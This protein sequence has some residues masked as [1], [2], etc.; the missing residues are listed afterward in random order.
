MSR[1]PFSSTSV[2]RKA[3]E[4]W[5][6]PSI[7][8]LGVPSQAWET[9]NATSQKRFNTQLL[10][11]VGFFGFTVLVAYNTVESNGT[12]AFVNTTGF[13]TKL[14]GDIQLSLGL[15]KLTIDDIDE[16]EDNNTIEEF[17]D[18]VSEDV[19][20][21][22]T[23]SFDEN[24]EDV[25]MVEGNSGQFVTNGSFEAGK[26]ST[27]KI[28]FLLDSSEVS[29]DEDI[30]MEKK[31]R[32][33][34]LG[35]I[36]SEN[37]LLEVKA[38]NGTIEVVEEWKNTELNEL[39][40]ND[41][42]ITIVGEIPIDDQIESREVLDIIDGRSEVTDDAVLDKAKEI[43]VTETADNRKEL[44]KE[45][46]GIKV[47]LDTAKVM[48]DVRNE[49]TDQKSIV[50]DST[51]TDSEVKVS[52]DFNINMTEKE[53]ICN[54]NLNGT[55]EASI[56]NPFNERN[57]TGNANI[58]EKHVAV[59]KMGSDVV[60]DKL[61]NPIDGAMVEAVF[62]YMET[63][64]V[65]VGKKAELEYTE[66]E[67]DV[68]K[69]N[70]EDRNGKEEVSIVKERSPTEVED[71]VIAKDGANE[72]VDIIRERDS[73]DADQLSDFN[74]KVITK[75]A[76][77]EVS[78]APNE[79]V[80]EIIAVWKPAED[81]LKQVDGYIEVIHI[82]KNEMDNENQI[83]AWSDQLCQE[84]SVKHF[85]EEG[86]NATLEIVAK[87]SAP[88]EVNA[89]DGLGVK[90]VHG[91]VGSEKED[92]LKIIEDGKTFTSE[93]SAKKIS[94]VIE[95]DAKDVED[96][97]AVIAKEG[98]NEEVDTIRGRDSKDTDPLSDVSDKAITKEAF[99]DGVSNAQ[100]EGVDEIIA[101]WKPSEDKVKPIDGNIE[102]IYIDKNEEEN[103]RQEVKAW[104]D[105][106][107][108]KD[109]VK[110][111]AEEI[112]DA[113][114]EIVAKSAMPDEVNANDGLGVKLVNGV[115]GSENEEKLEIVEDGQIFTSE[116]S[117][118]KIS[119]IIE[120]DAKDEVKDKEKQND[121]SGVISTKSAAEVVIE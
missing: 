42:K 111:L 117:A 67:Q 79:A 22:V 44:S 37:K 94:E 26:Q 92:K 1:K 36:D 74:D 34:L 6:R 50:S 71:A 35:K 107:R 113:T 43:I 11:G 45:I 59:I 47:D 7:E 120:P 54:K 27:G 105:Q 96:A 24:L 29:K 12:P 21:E 5:K 68:L 72:E 57:P 84:D 4:N 98:G 3:L 40:S 25:I 33:E 55:V 48:T 95:P 86:I 23:D 64:D 102:G 30:N 91:V 15:E 114:L 82:D 9:V 18:D 108:Q 116:V 61:E 90:S 70:I 101:V 87:S 83:K 97:A 65:D 103:E 17:T 109:S 52:E 8:E 66:L 19:K 78:N 81:K 80:G 118:D 73:K 89:N 119:E 63:E 100:N 93:F 76:L 121:V 32:G 104:S 28:E 38:V 31:T 39:V 58:E 10:A 106:L 49:I 56:E 75:K 46:M 99:E 41:E 69:V 51:E 14:P 60:K 77:D 2:R 62:S 53:G 115:I 13:N 16:V 20:E 110:H 112:I 88:D 85:A